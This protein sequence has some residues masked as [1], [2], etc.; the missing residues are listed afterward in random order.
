MTISDRDRAVVQ[1][2]ARFKQASSRQI[3]DALFYNN[4]SHVPHDR[5]LRRLVDT[6][7]LVRVEKRIVGGTRGGSGVYVYAL[8]RKGFF[9]YFDG[10]Y[11]PPRAINYHS[12]LIVDTFVALR[13]LEHAGV[14]SITGVS[15]EPDCHERIGGVTLKPDMFVELA[16][17]QG[18]RRL[19]F[20]EADM[21]TEGSKQLKVKFQSYYRAYQEADPA[22]WPVFPHVVFVAVDVEREREL[23][24]L[25]G[26]EPEHAQELFKVCTLET[27]ASMFA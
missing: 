25:I 11:S 9:T 19:L 23:T 18:K 6:G 5:A 3:H 12:L 15:T 20:I 2:V 27:L 4:S 14:L 21:A 7:Y 13:Q 26:R 24:W 8:G 22:E 16:S 10:R 1:L 17:P